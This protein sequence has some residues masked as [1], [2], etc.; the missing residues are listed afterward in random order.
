MAKLKKFE[1]VSDNGTVSTDCEISDTHSELHKLKDSKPI[2]I[3]EFRSF[4]A[5]SYGWNPKYSSV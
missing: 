5:D 2:F 1:D 3:G 4:A